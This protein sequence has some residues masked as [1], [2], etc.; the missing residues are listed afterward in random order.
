MPS[1]KN[2]LLNKKSECD[3][4]LPDRRHRQQNNWQNSN[5]WNRKLHQICEGRNAIPQEGTAQQTILNVATYTLTGGIVNKTMNKIETNEI[6]NW[7][8]SLQ[9]VMP[10]L[11][12]AFTNKKSENS[13]DN[14]QTNRPHRQKNNWQNL[15]ITWNEIE[16]QTASDVLRTQCHLWGM[17]CS[18]HNPQMTTYRPIIRLANKTKNKIAWNEIANC[19]RLEQDAVP[20]LRNTVFNDQ[21]ENGNVLP[22][23][24]KQHRQQNNWQNGTKWIENVIT[25][26]Q[27]IMR[28]RRKTLLKEQSEYDN[29]RP[30]RR[31]RQ[32]KNSQNSTKWNWKL[33]QICSGL[34]AIWVHGWTN[35][36][37]MTS[38]QLEAGSLNK[39][40]NKMAH[41]EIENCVRCIQDVMLSLRNELFNEQWE[42]D[43]VPP[44]KQHRQQ[45]N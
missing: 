5:K 42:N 30:S 37:K 19:T 34:H 36:R 31:H 1:L 14:V 25:L 43:T 2:A 3:N 44:D 21:S 12:N 18:T 35:N 33:H 40:I 8:R 32:Q 23:A 6:E 28:S 22:Q 15:K 27:D 10:S 11:R 41:H 29:V 4:V 7:I 26:V 38:Y 13:N 45:N 16:S 9:D 17:H 39:T 20:A 24:H